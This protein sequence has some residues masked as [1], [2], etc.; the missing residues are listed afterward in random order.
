MQRVA[1][2]TPVFKAAMTFLWA[3]FV[4]GGSLLLFALGTLPIILRGKPVRPWITTLLP[5]AVAGMASLLLAELLKYVIGRSGAYPDYLVYGK[6]VVKPMHA[7]SFPSAMAA[8]SSGVLSVWWLWPRGRA[9]YGLALAA[10]GV[11]LVITNSHWLSDVLAG[12]WLGS[13]LGLVALAQA[14]R[15]L[16]HNPHL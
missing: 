5:A 9:M 1:Y 13:L 14:Q 2:S 12:V 10:V 15:T 4:I 7:G 6:D 11:A 3:S 16:R 8:V